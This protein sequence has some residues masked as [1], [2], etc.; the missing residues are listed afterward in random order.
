VKRHAIPGLLRDVVSMFERYFRWSANARSGQM[1]TKT[2]FLEKTTMKIN[3]SLAVALTAFTGIILCVSARAQVPPAITTEPAGG[4]VA[5]GSPLT[6][7]V[8]AT[9]TPA[10][11]F[12]WVKDGNWVLNQ[13]NATLTLVSAQ[14]AN[15]GDYQVIVSNPAGSVTSVVAS[16]NIPGVDAGIGS[17]FPVKRECERRK[18]E[19]ARRTSIWATTCF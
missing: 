2:E 8:A 1:H 5:Q 13:T 15:I 10:P 18:W 16:V 12:Q 14:P 17:V 4:T 6:L 11:T 3:K 9:G 7:S 19:W